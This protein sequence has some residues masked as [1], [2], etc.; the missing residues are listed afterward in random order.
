M[1]LIDRYLLKLL[2]APIIYCLGGFMM[3]II[4]SEIFGDV[5]R[6][7]DA[8]PPWYI[9][10]RF[11]LSVL[12]PMLR[13][14]IPAALMLATLYTLFGLTRNSEL[15]AM[16]ATGISIYRLMTPFLFV[17]LMFS[18][19]SAV[20]DEFWAPR[21]NE[22]V[23][24]MKTTHFESRKIRAENASIF[25]N[26]TANRSWQVRH[27]DPQSPHIL[28]HVEI[29]QE[30]PDGT[31][32]HVI[33]APRAEFLDGQWWF[34]GPHIQRF[35]EIDNPIGGTAALGFDTN[36]IVEMRDYRETPAM[37]LSAARPWEFL[38]GREMLHYIRAN[39]NMP[40][41]VLQE[42]RYSLHSH[43]AM[44]W[45]SLIVILFAIPAGA[46]TARQG[47]MSAVFSAIGMMAGFYALA[48]L[49][50]VL[51]SSGTIPPWAGAWLS[52]IVFGIVGTY[53]LSHLR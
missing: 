19:L 44:P 31:R 3:I 53:H 6:I 21:A 38:N 35:G 40:D 47:V 17:G 15:V 30:R 24:N 22:W 2:I 43:F 33:T 11:Y 39:K 51:G 42:R 48:Q 26:I 45:A 13:Y 36:S 41:S 50:L 18:L 1:K 14:L 5:S 12:A 8:R 7:L 34:Y 52:N 27:I 10:L 28:H 32:E 4:I 25:I 46:R 49:G 23:E 16:R 20:L 9:V 29:K 37:L